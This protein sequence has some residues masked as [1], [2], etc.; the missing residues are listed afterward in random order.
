MF[1]Y[2]LLFHLFM[3]ATRKNNSWL[4]NGSMCP[5]WSN[6]LFIWPSKVSTTFADSHM[7]EGANPWDPKTVP[8]KEK[9]W[10]Y[11]EN[12]TLGKDAI[13]FMR[14]SIKILRIIFIKI[15]KFEGVVIHHV[16]DFAETLLM[17]LMAWSFILF[18]ISILKIFDFTLNQGPIMLTL[19]WDHL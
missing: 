5:I 3:E 12:K 14:N 9:V 17:M 1:S 10:A 7:N 19:L 6:I 4:Y 11:Q 18:E 2:F 15:F 16:L 13:F 8:S